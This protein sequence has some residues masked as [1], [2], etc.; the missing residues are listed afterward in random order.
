MRGEGQANL[1]PDEH[2]GE[3]GNQGRPHCST[4]W[5]YYNLE[6]RTYQTQTCVLSKLL[7]TMIAWCPTKQFIGPHRAMFAS[8]KKLSELTQVILAP[9]PPR[10]GHRAWTAPHMLAMWAKRAGALEITNLGSIWPVGMPE[11]SSEVGKTLLFIALVESS[12]MDLRLMA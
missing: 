2:W 5:F 4:F 12:R 10:P 9:S 8:Q 6:G 7:L 1:N 3:A 11:A